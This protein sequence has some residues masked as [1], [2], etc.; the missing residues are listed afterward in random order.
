IGL[1]YVGLTG[2]GGTAVYRHVLPGTRRII[3]SRATLTA[4][5][6]LRLALMDTQ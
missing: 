2:P 1:V 3:R 5:N 4:L 6:H